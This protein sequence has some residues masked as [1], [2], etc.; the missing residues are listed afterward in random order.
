MLVAS[1]G[2]RAGLL[3]LAD[4]TLA[5]MDSLITIVDGSEPAP[6]EKLA[7]IREAAASNP[8][9]EDEL[10]TFDKVRP[11]WDHFQKRFETLR[12]RANGD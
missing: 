7:A 4:Q 5:A 8:L 2:T 11:I 3:T 9:L 12:A 10:R 1:G 6:A